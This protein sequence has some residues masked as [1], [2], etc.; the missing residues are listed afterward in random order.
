MTVLTLPAQRGKDSG[1]N[2][3]PVP[4]QRMFW[5]TWRQHRATFISILAV[6]GAVSVFLVV[7]GLK[8]HHD[9][10]SLVATPKGSA[11]W[12]QLNR[13]FNSEDWTMG[14][15]LEILMQLAPVLI[16]MFAGGP[17]LARDLETGTFRYAWTQGLVRE[18]W[19]IAKL[20]LLGVFV[21]AVAGAFGQL[22]AWFFAPFIPQ[23]D[24]SV[25]NATVFGTRG[26]AFAAWTLAAFMIAAFGGMLLRRSIPAMATTLG[27]Y[28]GL[29]LLTWTEL[30]KHYP[31]ST[32]WPMQFVEGGWLLVLSILLAAAT[33][34]LVR[35]RAA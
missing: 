33:M 16:G 1:E 12:Q 5:V 4:W 26:I 35:H 21:A 13:Q 29:A 17:V 11:A 19:V 22:F 30:R 15:T 10:A 18:R 7:A 2:L 27:V 14:N 6:L 8:V 24:L 23:E 20:A 31:V 3:R 9:Y 32:F 34:W 25:L 28:L